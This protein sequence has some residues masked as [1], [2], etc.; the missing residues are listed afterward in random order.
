MPLRAGSDPATIGYNIH[1]MM[2]HGHPHLQA[3][4]AALHNAHYR[5]HRDDGGMVP[6]TSQDTPGLQPNVQTQTPQG[7]NLVQR[8]STM[9]PEQL[10]E[11]APR[12][13]GQMQQTAQ[14]V[15]RQKQMAPSY[16]QTAKPQAAMPQFG[17]AGS[18]PPVDQT[19]FAGGAVGYASGGATHRDNETVPILAAGGE[20]VISPDHV[21]ILGNGDVRAG[22]KLLD[23]W[24]VDARKQIVTKMKSLKG[25]VRG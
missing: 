7:Q 22:H 25:P 21:R 2:T 14:R 23:A 15:L 19:T 18:P 6:V 9:S 13:S 24:V 4:A 3:L 12:L 17:L 8:F 1:E 11:L 16:G 5:P 20:F 10:R